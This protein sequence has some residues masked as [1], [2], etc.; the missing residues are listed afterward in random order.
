MLEDARNHVGKGDGRRHQHDEYQQAAPPVAAPYE[1]HDQA[2]ERQ[3]QQR[4]RNGEHDA[5]HDRTAVEVER[6]EKAVVE[7]VHFKRE[8]MVNNE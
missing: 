6:Q 7:V 3:P 5:V 8:L 1:P 4:A 2:V